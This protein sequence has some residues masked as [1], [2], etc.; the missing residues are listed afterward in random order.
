MF[1]FVKW[2]SKDSTTALNLIWNAICIIEIQQLLHQ[3][4][5]LLQ[6]FKSLGPTP[7]EYEVRCELVTGQIDVGDSMSVH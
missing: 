4:L 3:H 1:E 6:P 2:L 5:G 7:A